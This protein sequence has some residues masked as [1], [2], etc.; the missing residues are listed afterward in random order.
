MKEFSYIIQDPLG[1]HSRPAGIL[2]KEAA[3]YSSAITL[4]REGSIANAKSIIHVMRLAVKNGDY[5]KISCCGEDEELA[6]GAL[7][8]LLETS[9]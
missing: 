3:K 7:K 9:L 2:V 4:E 1:L 5:I 8:S 6:S